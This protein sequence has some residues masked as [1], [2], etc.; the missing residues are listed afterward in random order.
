MV[1]RALRLHEQ[2]YMYVPSGSVLSYQ[3][4]LAIVPYP[5]LTYSQFPV[6]VLIYGG[7]AV[8][9][10]ASFRFLNNIHPR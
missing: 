6:R 1:G 8:L 7:S 4:T 10:I 2:Q 5:F 3:L 9:A